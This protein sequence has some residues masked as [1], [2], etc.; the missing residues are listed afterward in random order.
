MILLD[1]DH[2]SVVI[3]RRTTGHVAL[4][5]RLDNANDFLSVPVVC[6]EEQCK[7]WLAK[8]HHTRDIH[9]QISA[10]ERLKRRSGIRP[11]EDQHNRSVGFAADGV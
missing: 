2:L 8:I 3:N 11:F 1:T 7:G 9:Q 5:A 4:M 10:Y 6:V